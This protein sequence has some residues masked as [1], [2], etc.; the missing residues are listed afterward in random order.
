MNEYGRGGW[1]LCLS[2][3]FGVGG[4]F[5][6]RNCLSKRGL[7]SSNVFPLACLVGQT[8][9]SCWFLK[10]IYCDQ[11]MQHVGSKPAPPAMEVWALN[12]W[13]AR[14]VPYQFFF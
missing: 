2:W 14:E 1:G 13:T 8:P 9:L 10:F 4:D 6:Q 12:S 5:S 3:A 11:T 7:V